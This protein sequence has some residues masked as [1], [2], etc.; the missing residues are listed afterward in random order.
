MKL[1]YLLLSWLL[2]WLLPW[3]A[4][5]PALAQEAP[6]KRLINLQS[7]PSARPWVMDSA[8]THAWIDSLPFD[9]ITY[10]LPISW[11]LMNGEYGPWT[12]DDLHGQ[13]GELDHSFQN[14]TENFVAIHVRRR[15]HAGLWNGDFFDDAAW[16]ATCAELELLSEVARTPRYQAVGYVF[17][18]EEYF[19]Q[20]WNYPDD[21]DL[22]HLHSLEEYQDKARQRGR[23]FMQAIVGPWP[24]A[25]V[26]VLHGPYVSAP[27]RIGE[28]GV[29]MN[30]VGSPFEYELLGPFFLG[31]L[32]ASLWRG[33][34]VDGG[35]VY[36]LR[37]EED[38]AFNHCWRRTVMAHS[39]IVPPQQQGVSWLLRPGL[40]F[41]LYPYTWP[42]A[43]TGLM[44]PDLLRTAT[45]NAL[46]RADDWVWVFSEDSR[47]FLTPGGIDPAWIEAVR[48]GRLE[49]DADLTSPFA[50][51]T[52]GERARL[53]ELGQDALFHAIARL[54]GCP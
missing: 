49:A 50:G 4:S 21:V 45:R 10:N 8:G 36:Q 9:G 39:T 46:E 48:L 32:E 34:V 44:T 1:E 7:T 42:D 29:T 5:A 24:E 41:G 16:A 3:L 17:D 12:A 33:Q 40:S 25:R 52:A 20:V 23:E 2:P 35:E 53:R 30:Q 13:F 19:E 11:F 22:A 28:Y 31:M 26:L 54:M 18:N 6:E 43:A 27:E 47:D 14:V 38:F 51:L 15:N 37:S